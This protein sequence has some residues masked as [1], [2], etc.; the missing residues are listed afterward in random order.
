MIPFAIISVFFATTIIVFSYLD[1]PMLGAIG[2][3]QISPVVT[4][5]G[6]ASPNANIDVPKL[7]MNVPLI[8]SAIAIF[9]FYYTRFSEWTPSSAPLLRSHE[10]RFYTTRYKYLLGAT[11]YGL[12]MVVF[13]VL[14]SQFPEH[15]FAAAAEF[16]ISDTGGGLDRSPPELLA[17]FLAFFLVIWPKISPIDD[18]I[19]KSIHTNSGIPL[20]ADTLVKRLLDVR[21][22]KF[23]V[24]PNVV[25]KALLSEQKAQLLKRPDFDRNQDIGADFNATMARAGYL[26]A[27]L[28]SKES[29]TRYAKALK[30]QEAE[31]KDV[32]SVYDSLV[33]LAISDPFTNTP[34]SRKKL[35]KDANA[36][37]GR[38]YYI[39]VFSVLL[40]EGSNGSEPRVF[41][42]FGFE[43]S[44][45]DHWIQIDKN[46]VTWI[47]VLLF[48]GI[49]VPLCVFFAY[50]HASGAV[51]PPS[52][53]LA[54][55]IPTSW[56]EAAKWS[57]FGTLMHV[58]GAVVGVA[59]IRSL[60]L[61]KLSDVTTTRPGQQ[62]KAV[63]D[64]QP[65]LFGQM[66]H[67]A[68]MFHYLIAFFTAFSMAVYVIAFIDIFD[69]RQMTEVSWPWA[70]LPGVTGAFTAFNLMYIVTQ[71]GP[72]GIAWRIL[73][74]ATA[75]GV[76]ALALSFV[77]VLDKEQ[78]FADPVAHP[79][80]AYCGIAAFFIG[81]LV[82]YVVLWR[83][84]IRRLA[85]MQ[86]YALSP[87]AS[88]GPGE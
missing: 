25:D 23:Q 15:F 3:D 84:R 69:P 7:P 87:N 14:S 26:L 88:P 85:Y 62:L 49:L 81:A 39:V 29:E 46:A 65:D 76:A 72:D 82:A 41:R 36:L 16:G 53:R 11:L 64:S 43:L 45:T 73:F 40:A 52:S 61:E 34:E 32:G 22:V 19:R 47:A 57:G 58:A 59:V 44:D 66:G 71:P 80:I 1:L 13:F 9:F 48:L 77:L 42:K 30:Q 5:P 50:T 21:R 67:A 24:S 28:D 70:F 74:Q 10:T 18:P 4:A 55:F 8:V 35:L 56:G 2:L 12:L 68:Y 51:I 83:Y 31:H 17:Y 27:E 38:I 63:G 79:F 6:T 33:E 75:T 78:V 20:Q 86:E 37:L 54:T 60:V